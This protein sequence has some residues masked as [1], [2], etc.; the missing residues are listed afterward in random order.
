MISVFSDQN[1]IVRIR[2]AL[3]H[4]SRRATVM[5]GSGLSKCASK[6]RPD[7]S[8]LPLWRDLGKEFS[9]KLYLQYDGSG[10]CAATSVS[11]D[12]PRLAQ[13]FIAEF[14][15]EEMHRV[16]QNQIRDDDFNPGDIHQRLLQL[17][18]RD[19]FTTN[20]D[21]LLERTRVAENKYGI[22]RNK[23]QIPLVD[24]P[25]IVKLHGSF[26]ADFP[27]ICTEEDYRTYPNLYAP[28][29]NTV[30]QAMM[31]TVFCLIGFS[32]DD[33]N[34]LS[35]SGWVRDNLGTSA[36][37]IYL[38]G[39]L[40]LQTSQ[41]RMLEERN[42]V[43]I[44]LANHPMANEWPEHR[45]YHYAINWILHTLERGRPYD[46]A[47]WPAR[48][49]W[50]YKQIPDDLRPVP[51]IEIEEPK[52][53]WLE[54]PAADSGNSIE[55]V[56]RILDIWAHNRSLYP[57]WLAVPAS[58]RS[59]MHGNTDEHEPKILQILPNLTPVHRLDAIRELVW[60]REVLLDPISSELES[61]ADD[62]L[63]QID[64]QA[65]AVDG[66]AETRIAWDKIREAW[67]T[68]ALALVTAS[69][70]R[71]DDAVFQR[72]I[73]AL[74][75]FLN[76]DPEIMQRVHHERCLWSVCSMDF[77]ESQK[78]LR[79]WPTENCDPIWMV[80]KAAILYEMHRTGEAAELFDRA[81]LDIRQIPDDGRSVASPSRESWA[82]WLAWALEWSR[83]YA[84]K[85]EEMPVIELFFHQRMRELAPLN[86]DTLSEI[87]EYNNS[88]KAKSKK[89]NAPSFDLGTRTLPGYEFSNDKYRRWVGARRV[90]R[91]SEVA[92]LPATG[93]DILKSAVDVLSVMDEPEL[94]VRLILRTF[95]YDQ[96]DVLKRALSRPRVARMDQELVETLADACDRIIKYASRVG[97]S[98]AGGFLPTWLDR[99]RVAMEVLSRLVIRLESDKVEA[100]F[101][102]ALQIYES[103]GHIGSA[104]SL[105]GDAVNSMLT[106][107]WETLPEDKRARHV[108]D[109]LDAPIVG[110]DKFAVDNNRYPDP[111]E[112]LNDNLPLPVRENR[113]RRRWSEMIR[114]LVRGLEEGG[115][116]RKRA[117]IRIFFVA[118][119]NNLSP[120]EADAIAGALWNKASNNQYLP[121]ETELFDWVFLILP[122]PEQ[123]LAEQNYR[124]KWLMEGESMNGDTPGSEDV[125]RQVGNALSGLAGYGRPLDISKAERSYLTKVIKKWLDSPIPS[126]LYPFLKYQLRP[127]RQAI[128]GLLL[129]ISKVVPPQSIGEE[130]FEKLQKLQARGIP[131]YGSVV[132]LALALPGRLQD[133]ASWMR[134]GLASDDS[135]VAGNATMGLHYW[136]KES[137]AATSRLRAPPEDLVREIGVMIATRRKASLKQALHAAQWIFD[138]GSKEQQDT[139]RDLALQGLKYLGEELRYN[140]EPDY[141]NDFELPMLRL[142]STRLA[143]TMA[144]RGFENDSAV[145]RWLEIARQDPLPEVRYVKGLTSM[146]QQKDGTIIDNQPDTDQ[147]LEE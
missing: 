23:D 21:T 13:E 100:R 27:L 66:V 52:Y 130:I 147:P 115:E 131:G 87:G 121:V 42:V 12:F 51:E 50:R 97:V 60:R 36:P 129:I 24:G 39:W 107:T 19:V 127:T 47:D 144:D 140:R 80:R 26:P 108:I 64:C 62:V 20:W 78:L 4:R 92:G 134:V 118:T 146:R 75:I 30:Q 126:P 136:L 91:L 141:E 61:A 137:N 55:F 83:W 104:A 10:H 82:L 48:R 111:G 86:C 28:F 112:L 31:E 68:V 29:V 143:K 56:E 76:D 18:W 90:V 122:E 2:E 34:F 45:R 124:R 84:S 77:Q 32:G 69:R 125:L 17:P 135:E 1:Y 72:R 117:S 38:A 119:K 88:M 22:V 132:G 73:E 41:R 54:G 35:W 85:D 133:I 96:D 74:S 8:D 15:R 94:A 53:E 14:G 70:H 44:D 6:A 81:L 79:D 5:I 37:K 63:Q 142:R 89:A 103:N 110:L 43:P 120:G 128:Q 67:V 57:G 99:M 65:R 123:G 105:L 11:R 49:T 9:R 113:D 16:L 7:A 71:F 59:D 46:V 95:S 106:R 25:R 40:K 101:A 138:E 33:P 93:S 58:A 3:W 116:A 98:G 109:I 102:E 114:L 139:I 145:V